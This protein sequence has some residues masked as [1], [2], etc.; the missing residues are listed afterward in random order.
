MSK[1]I[2][3]LYVKA[4]KN[5]SSSLGGKPK[6][7]EKRENSRNETHSARPGSKP[8]KRAY[9]TITAVMIVTYSA[10][11]KSARRMFVRKQN[12]PGTNSSRYAARATSP[13]GRLRG[14]TGSCLRP[15]R[16]EYS[17]P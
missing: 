7:E 8:Y 16:T 11:E 15:E 1:A 4:G 6:K 10:R 17:L 12:V 13:G 3:V 5:E 9:A 14:Q 2:R